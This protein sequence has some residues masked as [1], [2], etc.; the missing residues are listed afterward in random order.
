MGEI[1]R[2]SWDTI[3]R[4]QG[5]KRKRGLHLYRMSSVQHPPA[6]C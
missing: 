4:K 5:D 6:L 3:K 1:H 2:G